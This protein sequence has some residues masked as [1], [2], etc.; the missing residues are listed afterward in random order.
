MNI[1]YPAVVTSLLTFAGV[2]VV[3]VVA[4]DQLCCPLSLL[5]LPSL[6]MRFLATLFIVVT[7]IVA[8]VAVIVAGVA[9]T[10]TTSA[11]TSNAATAYVAVVAVIVAGVAA[12]CSA[13][14]L[15]CSWHSRQYS[16]RCRIAV[17]LQ[18]LV[19]VI[20]LIS[21]G[22]AVLIVAIVPDMVAVVAG[23]V[24]LIVTDATA[25]YV[26]CC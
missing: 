21:G 13:C 20:A 22:V 15:M 4:A 3:A 25:R 7:Q 10:L 26:C 2:A 1:M 17:G 6:H 14:S 9:I 12:T 19:A 18:P 24:V 8:G 16:W 23:A 11:C 5:T